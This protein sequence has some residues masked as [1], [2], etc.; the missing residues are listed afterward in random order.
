MNI[1]HALSLRLSVAVLLTSSMLCCKSEIKVPHQQIIIKGS[2]SE[3]NLLRFFSEEYTK[4]HQDVLLEVTG[5]GTT[6]GIN[7]LINGDADI[8]SASRL[9]TE[10]E[11][12]EAKS[13]GVDPVAYITASDVVA[14]ITHPEV[15]VDS[16]SLNQLRK[17]MRG[18]IHN[19]KDVGGSDLPVK[20]YGRDNNSGT[21]HFLMRSLNCEAF[22]HLHANFQ[23]NKEI[24]ESVSNEQGA[25]GYVN[26]GSIVNK[27]GKPTDKV[28]AMNLYV[29][30][31]PACSPYERERIKSAEYPLTRALIQYV[32]ARATDKIMSFIWFELDEQQ[33]ENLEKHGFIHI[34]ENQVALNQK[35][36][37]FNK[38]QIKF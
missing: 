15:G 38:I 11:L 9:M 33:Q 31:M 36:G 2:D 8:A 37:C 17:I 16:I 6:K 27:E 29:D 34:S 25:I 5:G 14:I 26:L 22:S 4:Q 10:D 13:K 19:W 21:R 12:K 24:I 28:W 1:K 20:I 30:G 23:N 3:L 7:A 32:N 18:D 35:N